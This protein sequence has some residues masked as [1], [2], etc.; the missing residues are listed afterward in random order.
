[1]KA[2]LKITRWLAPDAWFLENPVGLLMEMP[3]MQRYGPSLNVCSYCRYGKPYR[4]NTCI[5]SNVANLDLKTCS[6]A[7]LCKSKAILGYH[8][9]TAQSGGTARAVGS[10]GGRNV[11][12]IPP[13]LVPHA[14]ARAIGQA[15]AGG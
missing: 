14:F 11:Y 1:M 5:W 15:G 6:G 2:G 3:W 10:G 7:N 9:V 13:R 8:P 12:P 4:K